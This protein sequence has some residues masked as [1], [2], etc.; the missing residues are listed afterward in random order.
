MN[1]YFLILYDKENRFQNIVITKE[2]DLYMT[3]LQNLFVRTKNIE[4]RCYNFENQTN[5]RGIGGRENQGAKGHAFD[6]IRVGDT[7]VLLDV[8]GSGVIDHIWITC[9]NADG[10]FTPEILRGLR[11]DMYWDKAQTPAVSAPL[12]DFFG[13]GLG[14]LANYENEFFSCPCMKAF[15]CYIPMPFLKSARMTITNDTSKDIEHIF[16]TVNYRLQEIVKEN[17]MY[18]HA[19]WHRERMTKLKQD[20]EILP[21]VAGEGRYL[22]ANISVIANNI[23]EEVWWGEGEIKIYSDGDNDYPTIVG[24]GAEDYAG[25]AWGLTYFNHRYQGCLVADNENKQWSFYRYHVPD[26]IYFYKY[27]KVTMQQIG[28]AH[29]ECL[30]MLK[31]KGVPIEIVSFDKNGSFIKIL[32]I[33]PKLELEDEQIKSKDWCNIFRQDDWA[34]TAYFYLDRPENQLPPLA[35]VE[36]R[37]AD[38]V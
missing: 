38:L 32:E 15:N 5:L 17:M 20:F 27:C 2:R 11:I 31:A 21:N 23:Y 30:L 37:L 19:Y 33:N 22:G 7:K 25:T 16:Y 12:G 28:G 34:A 8:T 4:R 26:P 29:K 18:F 10:V 24:T 14:R 13:I 1:R 3:T 9:Q 36:E 6:F 35:F